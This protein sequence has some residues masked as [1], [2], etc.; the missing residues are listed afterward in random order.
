MPAISVMIKPVSGACNMRCRYCFYTDVMN[1]REVHMHPRMT[2][3]TLETTVRRVMAY[4]DDSVVFVLQGGEPTLIGLPFLEAMVRFQRMYNPRRIRITNALQTNGYDLSDEMIDF[5]RKED[6]LLGVSLD[7]DA[8]AHD[9]MR[10]DVQGRGT[11][12]R[13]MQTVERL[14]KAQVAYNILCVVNDHV[15]S[16]PEETLDAL[17]RFGHLQLI[18]CLDE[19]DGTKRDYAL[20]DEKYLRFLTAAFDRYEA[21]YRAG[22]PVSIRNFDNWIG[23]MMGRPPENCAMGGRCSHQLVVES[24]GS[25]YPCDFYVLDEW[26]CG[27]INQSGVRKLL[28]SETAE[29]FIAPSIPV[30]DRCRVCRWYRLCRNGCRRERDPETGLFRWCGVMEAFFDHAAVRMARM[31]REL[32]K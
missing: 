18:P 6:F 21:A 17:F 2:L 16:R 14:E 1:R 5:F 4:A 12:T 15:A 27:S 32:M 30:P 19:L 25:V 23:M 9:A 10:P 31:A 29:A 7:G 20:T 28:K 11:Y 13:V 24:D 8:I 3:E 22:R 26:N